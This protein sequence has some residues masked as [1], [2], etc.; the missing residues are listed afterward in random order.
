MYWCFGSHNK[1]SKRITHAVFVPEHQ[2]QQLIGSGSG[3]G[4]ESLLAQSSTI[5]LPFIA[6]PSSPA[7]F[8]P[9]SVTQSPA[10]LLSL[11]INTYS[12]RCPAIFAIGPYAHETQLVTPPVFSAFTTE[13]STALCTPP[14]ESVTF[15]TTSPSSPEV[16]FA[17]LLTSS[18]ERARRNSG[19]KFCYSNSGNCS[20]FVE[21]GGVKVLGIGGSRLGSGSLT[22]DGLGMGG[23]GCLTPDGLQLEYQMMVSEVVAESSE[24][25]VRNDGHVIDHHRVSFELSGEEVARCLTNKYATSPRFISKDNEPFDGKVMNGENQ[26]CNEICEKSSG[27]G[28][29][30]EQCYRKQ[31]SITLGSY[32]E[33]NFDNAEGEASDKPS[34]S[35]SEWWSN[36]KVAG[37]EAKS[38][39]NWTFFPMLQSEV[40]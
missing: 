29:E 23:S 8:E 38:S 28:E 37:K 9:P 11:S 24:N 27:E 20:P 19:V 22:P 31:R 36:E 39:S 16:P 17:Q 5:V 3:S 30:E 35:S 25:Q 14:P 13:P 12:P 21:K 34:T 40:R 2:Q 1:T 15:A 18:L 10:G 33:F 7:S 6:P 26:T 4:S 32:K